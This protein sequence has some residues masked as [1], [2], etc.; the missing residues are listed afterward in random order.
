MTFVSCDELV[1]LIRGM[2]G[3]VISAHCCFAASLL[4]NWPASTD[5][6]REH[7]TQIRNTYF[8]YILYMNI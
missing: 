3:F 8:V 6:R 7:T 2:L 5:T 1:R 4:L